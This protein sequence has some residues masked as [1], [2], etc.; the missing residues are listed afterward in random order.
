MVRTCGH[1]PRSRPTRVQWTLLDARLAKEGVARL[2]QARRAF[3]AAPSSA[4][5][6]PRCTAFTSPARRQQHGG[7]VAEVHLGRRPPPEGQVRT[8]VVVQLD[9]PPTVPPNAGFSTS[10]TRGPGRRSPSTRSSRAAF[11][12]HCRLA[13]SAKD[14][15]PADLFGRPRA[16]ARTSILPS[17]GG[18]VVRVGGADLRSSDEG[19][20]ADHTLSTRSPSSW[21]V[22]RTTNASRHAAVAQSAG[23]DAAAG[24]G[25]DGR[26]LLEHPPGPGKRRPVDVQD[27][28][29]SSAPVSSPCQPRERRAAASATGSDSWAQIEPST[30]ISAARRPAARSGPGSTAWS[31]G[32]PRQGRRRGRPGSVAVRPQQPGLAAA[33][34]ECRV[35]DTVLVDHE[36]VYAPRQSNDRLLLGLKGSLNEYELTCCGSAP[37]ATRRP[38]AASWS[39]P[40]RLPATGRR[41][42]TAGCRRPSHKVEEHRPDARGSSNTDF[43]PTTARPCGAGPALRSLIAN[44]VYGGAY[45]GKSRAVAVYGESGVR[46]R[47]ER[48]P[49]DEWLALKPGTHAWDR[50]EAAR[51]LPTTC[52]Q[53]SRR[54]QARRRAD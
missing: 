9:S 46:V 38:G 48:R 7:P 54:R 22:L 1:R 5:R 53:T 50:A 45:H 29:P 44:P 28:A 31:G 3:G 8:S 41:I 42:P 11:P 39:P 4:R 21:T 20:G 51:W 30:T 2:S 17:A 6:L 13:G 12:A 10:S 26:M 52:Q 25:S 23:P 43:R 35:V 16:G 36:A 24:D 18:F 15:R 49:R 14:V 34:R 40:G 33:D 27:P 37:R 19:Q 32:L 47:H